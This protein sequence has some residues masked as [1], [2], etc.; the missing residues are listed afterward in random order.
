MKQGEDI[1]GQQNILIII[2]DTSLN[3]RWEKVVT[4]KVK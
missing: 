2:T 4:I 1:L 3:I